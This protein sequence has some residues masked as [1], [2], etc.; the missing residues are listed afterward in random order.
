MID[1]FYARNFQFNILPRAFL[2]DYRK[3]WN[4]IL[5]EYAGNF[6]LIDHMREQ[7]KSDFHNLHDE[8]LEK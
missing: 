2:T 4:E 3:L 8:R 1:P 5:E 6:E 7:L